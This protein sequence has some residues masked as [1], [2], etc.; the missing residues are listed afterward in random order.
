MSSRIS[1]TVEELANVATHGFGLVAS[2]AALPAFIL[3]AARGGDLWAII[4]VA[5]FGV[6]LVGAY[7]ASTVY[8]AMPSG[9]HKD[10]WL[11]LD[12]SAVFL[13]IAGTYTPFTLGALRGPWGWTLFCLIWLGALIGIC[14][15]VRLRV[16]RPRIENS[17]YLVLGWLVVIAIDPL[18]ERIGWGGLLWL[19]AGGVAYSIGVVFLS[20]RRRFAHCAWHVFVLAGSACHA[21]AVIGYAIRQT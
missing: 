18:L 10:R 8:H 5:V 11:R 15:R 9:P 1:I 17:T 20:M 16:R 14:A 12:Q 3:F 19:L 2:L 4:G 21:V 6:T 7:A 13:L